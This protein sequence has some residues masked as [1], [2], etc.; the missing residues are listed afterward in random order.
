MSLM[1]LKPPARTIDI[2]GTTAQNVP[3][4]GWMPATG[5]ADVMAVVRLSSVEGNL[6]VLPTY[7]VAST[8]LHNP[9]SWADIGSTAANETTTEICSAKQSLT[10]GVD[11]FFIRFGVSIASDT[12]QPTAWNRAT[13]QLFIQARD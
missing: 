1:N 2:V 6:D 4:T 11:D 13:I 12:G 3:M 10:I 7:Q 8:D 5:L 9:G